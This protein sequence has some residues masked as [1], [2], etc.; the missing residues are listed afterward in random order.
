MC[1]QY[2]LRMTYVKETTADINK[3]YLDDY[4]PL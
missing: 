2:P 3:L 4:E 1:A